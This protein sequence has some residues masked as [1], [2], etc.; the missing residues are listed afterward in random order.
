MLQQQ[1]TLRA[2]DRAKVWYAAALAM[3][4]MPSVVRKPSPY[5]L[6]LLDMEEELL[7]V[8]LIGLNDPTQPPVLILQSRYLLCQVTNLHINFPFEW[9]PTH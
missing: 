7:I 3:P 5:M 2:T 4:A 1:R 9:L 6:Q 8:G